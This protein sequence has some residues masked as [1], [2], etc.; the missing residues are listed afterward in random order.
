MQKT[1]SFSN[2][3]DKRKKE[4]LVTKQINNQGNF[5]G[6][7]DGIQYHLRLDKMLNETF[8]LDYVKCEPDKNEPIYINKNNTYVC[9]EI[10]KNFDLEVKIEIV[11]CFSQQAAYNLSET[12]DRSMLHDYDD[13]VGILNFASAK[14][15]GGGW[16]SGANAQEESLVRS[17]SLSLSLES[18]TKNFYNVNVNNNNYSL[19]NHITIVS[20]HVPFYR[21]NDGS[22]KKPSYYTVVSSPAP[23]AGIAKEKEIDQKIINAYLYRRMDIILDSFLRHGIHNI[24]LGAFGC[25]VFKNDPNIVA[26]YWNTLLRNKY[27]NSFNKVIFA[28][29]DNNFFA[30]FKQILD[31]DL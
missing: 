8:V 18:C 14:N 27:K 23:N 31:S 21:D 26:T 28:I 7:H 9:E 25:G 13:L 12:L 20:P 2:G 10:N 24:V 29:P 30:L 4:A 17:S 22:L 5:Y 19:Y 6:T 15:P 1:N 11:K 3:K 16:K